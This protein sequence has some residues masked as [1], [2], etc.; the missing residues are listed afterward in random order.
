MGISTEGRFNISDM[1]GIQEKDRNDE[2]NSLGNND[3]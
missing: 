3:R 1:R 2:R